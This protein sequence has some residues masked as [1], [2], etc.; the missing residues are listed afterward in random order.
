MPLELLREAH[1]DFLVSTVENS[2]VL[3]LPSKPGIVLAVHSVHLE[4]AEGIAS[5][6]AARRIGLSHDLNA[7]GFDTDSKS[8]WVT[9]IVQGSGLSDT[10]AGPSIP[11]KYFVPPFLIAGPQQLVHGI[12][13]NDLTI[14]RLSLYFTEIKVPIIE[15]T[16]LLRRTSH[17]N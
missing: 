1:V 10:A 8:V 15:Y 11:P 7:S 3:D 13:S 12:G 16:E 9:F 14:H 2:F 4:L 5:G 17:E 6:S